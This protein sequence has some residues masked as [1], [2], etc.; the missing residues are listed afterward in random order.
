[1]D[2]V[3]FNFGKAKSSAACV[4]TAEPPTVT[5][6]PTAGRKEGWRRKTIGKWEF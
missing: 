3:V 1:M 2:F 6:K 5:E 4:H